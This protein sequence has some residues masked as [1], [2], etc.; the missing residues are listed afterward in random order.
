MPHPWGATGAIL[1][2]LDGFRDPGKHAGLR[3]AKIWHTK[4]PRRA[5]VPLSLEV[6]GLETVL[7]QELFSLE[8]LI[9]VLIDVPTLGF[10]KI[11][12]VLHGL[13]SLVLV[14]GLVLLGLR[15]GSL[16]HQGGFS[17]ASCCWVLESF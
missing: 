10:T 17:L 11:N 1:V 12:L 15:F 4:A 13:G 14:L 7:L 5:F 6:S 9:N 3:P 2:L 8:P 16:E